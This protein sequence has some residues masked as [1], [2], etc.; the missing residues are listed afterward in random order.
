[1][2]L[3]AKLLALVLLPA[4]LVPT[5]LTAGAPPAAAAADA[6]RQSR[7]AA[8]KQ[9][10]PPGREGESA[11]APAGLLGPLSGGETLELPPLD[12]RVPRPVAALGSP[13]GSR[14]S[15][16]ERI[17]AYFEALA[18]ASPRVKVWDYG[19][20]YEGRPLKL[21]AITSPA[22]LAR[23]DDIRAQ[24]LR[25]AEPERL[26]GSERERLAKS[27]PAVVW[28]AYGVHGD[29]ASS[30]ETAMLLAYVLAA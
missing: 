16:W 19:H 22:N 28:L 9:A 12:E 2:P 25:L 18:A 29:E 1:M 10:P 13:V 24:R 3:K 15:H 17:A 6:R 21:A 26:S 27:L 30:S 7:T 20:T 5:V 14:F 11:P 23:L 4:V 8:E